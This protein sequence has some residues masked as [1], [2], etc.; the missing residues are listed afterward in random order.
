M[1]ESQTP[2]ISRHPEAPARDDERIELLGNLPFIFLHAGCLLVLVTGWSPAAIAVFF[3]TLLPRMFGLTAGYH[4]YFSHRSFKTS[5]FFQFVLAFLGACSLQKDPLW[6]AA[7]HRQHHRFADTEFDAHPPGVRGFF[8]AHMGWVMCKKNANLK[9]DE[10][11]PDL[12]VYPE[13]RFLHEH[14]KFPA[15]FMLGMLTAAGYAMEH[16]APHLGTSPLQIVVWGFFISTIVL[17]HVTFMVNS[18][19]HLWGGR[20]FNTRDMSHNNA[21][22]A[23]LT[24]GE[25]W[26]NNHHRFP[27]SE[28]MGFYWWEIDMTHYILKVLSWFGVVWDLRKPPREVYEEAKRIAAARKS[29]G[30]AV[31]V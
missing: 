13:L 3:L 22:V 7:H 16:F 31:T 24:M 11:V 8:W 27:S 5:R 1:Q 28:R 10:L 30:P 15:L 12:M 21:F 2:K 23:I 20:R 18:V 25:G 17:H 14:Q 4:R 19:A 26:H 9:P 29:K 6:W